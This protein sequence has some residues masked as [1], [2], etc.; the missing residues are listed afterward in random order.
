MEGNVKPKGKGTKKDC[1]SIIQ[2]IVLARD[3]ICQH[4]CCSH[5]AESGHHV[6]K[7]D[8]LAVAFLPEALV[9]LCTQHHTG[10][11]HGDPAAFKLFMIKRLGADRYYE[12]RRKSYEVVK[13]LDYHEIYA[14]FVKV[15][16]TC[17]RGQ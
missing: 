1:Y 10:W 4:P 2:E 12:L 8:R 15:L 17:R 11:A 13:N 14:G 16:R 5:Q 7:R 9:G 6:W 3:K